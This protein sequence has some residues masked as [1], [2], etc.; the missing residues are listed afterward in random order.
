[1]SQFNI[2]KSLNIEL[3]IFVLMRVK[4][5]PCMQDNNAQAEVG[6]RTAARAVLHLLS[7]AL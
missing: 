2:A 5:V 7:I 3:P 4:A 6:A 1:M